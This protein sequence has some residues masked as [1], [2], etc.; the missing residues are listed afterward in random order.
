V[1]LGVGAARILAR[2]SCINSPLGLMLAYKIW[3]ASDSTPKAGV[4]LAVHDIVS[5]FL[6]QPCF[7]LNSFQ[8]DNASSW[9]TMAPQLTSLGY[10]VFA[11]DLPGKYDYIKK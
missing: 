4:I 3:A 6:L 7:V 2:E 8:L 5:S 11:P 10:H 1:S 9:D